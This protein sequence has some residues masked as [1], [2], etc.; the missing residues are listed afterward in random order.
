MLAPVGGITIYE[1]FQLDF[2]PI[3]LQLDASLG[4]RIMEYV[5]P[6]RRSRNR[7]SDTASPSDTHHLK[8]RASLDSSKLL[9]QPRSSLDSTGLT[10]PLRKLGSSR[11]FTDLRSAAADSTITP[12]FDG[13]SNQRSLTADALDESRRQ[14]HA[15]IRQVSLEHK[16]DFD[17]MKTRS[18]QKNFV[19]VKISRLVHKNERLPTRMLKTISSLELLLSIMKASSF[20]CRDARIRTHALEIRNQ[21]WSVCF[22]IYALNVFD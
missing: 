6:A 16:T 1:K 2:H 5:W 14:R 17:E 15:I 13:Q 10:P 12:Y 18:S 19:L 21:T 20:E 8:P 7:G 11:S 9:N 4:Q 22:M 3:R